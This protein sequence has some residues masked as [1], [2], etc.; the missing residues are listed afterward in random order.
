MNNNTYQDSSVEKLY[1]SPISDR[2]DTERK[3]K[4]KWQQKLRFL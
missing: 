2:V 3:Q 1:I 4:N